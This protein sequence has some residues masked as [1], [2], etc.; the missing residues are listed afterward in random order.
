MIFSLT[1]GDTGNRRATTAA[2]STR[3][4]ARTPS[5]RQRQWAPAQ[6]AT[7]M[8]AGELLSRF[9]HA[10]HILGNATSLDLL[11]GSQRLSHISGNATSLDL[12][13]ESQHL[14]SGPSQSSLRAQ[15]NPSQ[16]IYEPESTEIVAKAQDQDAGQVYELE[17]DIP[18]IPP[19]ELEQ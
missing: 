10:S 11:L 15:L 13:L 17:G 19:V 12:Q 5:Q 4:A 6:R 9:T 14:S 16:Q 18:R 7:N 3:W 2:S 1:I 8:R